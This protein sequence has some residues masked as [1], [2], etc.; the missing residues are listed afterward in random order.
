MAKAVAKM[1]NPQ[2]TPGEDEPI[3]ISA[4]GIVVYVDRTGRS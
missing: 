3:G 4:V 1:E 2:R